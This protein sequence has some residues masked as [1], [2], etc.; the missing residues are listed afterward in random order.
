[1]IEIYTDGACSVNPGIGGW[2]AVLIYESGVE[3]EIY[4]SEIETTN[5]RMEITAVIKSLEELGDEQDIKIYS[6]STYVINTITKNWKRNANNDLW[7]ILD[8]LL[9]DKKVEWQWVK[10]HSGN[11][12]NEIADK[13]AVNAINELKKNNSSELSH[14]DD[15]G[16]IK[17]VDVSEKQITS[18]VA[19]VSGKVVMKKETLE[20]IKKGELAKGDIFTL[21]RTAGITAAKSTPTLI[22]LC[23][24]IPLSEIKIEIEPDDKLPGLNVYCST[25]ADWKTGVEIEAFTGVSIACVTIYDMCKA[26]DKSAYITDIKLEKKSGGLSGDYSR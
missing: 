17:M 16:S 8:K 22:P 13:L 20:I 2:G 15:D 9:S 4:G 26:V 19:V 10:G 18:R 23:H 21:S 6:D 14:L 5:N 1:M 12:Y 24:T 25:K 7:D 11:K 3:K